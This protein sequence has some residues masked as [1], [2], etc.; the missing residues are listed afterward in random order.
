MA[1]YAEAIELISRALAAGPN[2]VFHNNLA[3]AYLGTGSLSAA[4]EQCRFALRLKPDFPDA[5]FNL[6]V[7]LSRQGRYAEAVSSLREAVRLAPDHVEA[8]C[9]LGAALTQSGQLEEALSVLSETA[10]LNPNHAQTR[11]DLGGAL[12][13]A[14]RIED[15]IE[16]F[17]VAIKLQPAH[18]AAHQN[19]GL[20]FREQNRLDDA[21]AS[22][23]KAV[24]ID[25]GYSAARNSLAYALEVQQKFDDAIAVYRDTL[26]RD[27]SNSFAISS[28]SFLAQS[29]RYS[30]PDEDV[31]RIEAL[32]LSAD[33][34]PDD[35][36]RLYF[37]IGNLFDKQGRWTEAFSNYESGNQLRKEIEARRGSSSIRKPTVMRSIRSSGSLRKTISRASHPM[38]S[39]ANCLFL[40]SACRDLVRRWPNKFLRAIPRFLA[41][42]SYKIYRYSS[43]GSA[44]AYDPGHLSIRKVFKRSTRTSQVPSPLIT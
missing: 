42:A 8:R 11:N 30:F 40:S 34:R 17:R 29:G 41:P 28:L 22:F 35:R 23:R 15:A 26:E 19:L 2:P 1:R 44:S 14:R 25:P 5:H 37:A 24:Q 12:L 13:V 43:I 4:E 36:S 20:A 18:A 16:Q 6:G 9:N 31:R 7:S 38:A 21:I 10:A 39:I 33:M 3:A 32:L 27:P